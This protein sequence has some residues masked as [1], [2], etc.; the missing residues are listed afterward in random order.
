MLCETLLAQAMPAKVYQL[1]LP[2]GGRGKFKAVLLC[3]DNC[4]W[5]AAVHRYVV[6]DAASVRTR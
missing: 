5:T 4:G 3:K 2:F 6:E 1:V